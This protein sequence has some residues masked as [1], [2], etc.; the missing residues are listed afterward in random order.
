[1]RRHEGREQRQSVMNTTTGEAENGAAILAEGG[2]EGPQR[3]G[4]G[5][6][7]LHLRH[8][9]GAEAEAGIADEQPLGR[10]RHRIVDGVFPQ[11][12]RILGLIAT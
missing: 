3:R 5:A 8:G 6:H 12:C 11:P 4:L 10:G 7:R 9:G 2:P 1:M